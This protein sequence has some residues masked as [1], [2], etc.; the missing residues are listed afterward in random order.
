MNERKW[1]APVP[2]CVCHAWMVPSLLPTYIILYVSRCVLRVY[3]YVYTYMCGIN[4]YAILRHDWIS[5][6]VFR[7]SDHDLTHRQHCIAA[8]RRHGTVEAS[9]E[10]KV[11]LM[12][13]DHRSA[14]IGSNSINCEWMKYTKIINAL[15]V[16]RVYTRMCARKMHGYKDEWIY[17]SLYRQIFKLLIEFWINC[18]SGLVTKHKGDTIRAR[19]A[20]TWL[21]DDDYPDVPCVIGNVRGKMH[22][23]FVETLVTIIFYDRA[24]I[25]SE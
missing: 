15:I 17:A 12:D 6:M 10:F 1:S 9:L 21:S 19:K 20:H 11:F 2:P 22:N 24:W 3:V 5:R 25:A 14:S 7:V 18:S 16:A 8:P 13:A 4:M 23:T